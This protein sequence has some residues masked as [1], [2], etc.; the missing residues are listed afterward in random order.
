MRSVTVAED[1]RPV[2]TVTV[3]AILNRVH[4]TGESNPVEA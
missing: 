4:S 1:G 3:E 2:G